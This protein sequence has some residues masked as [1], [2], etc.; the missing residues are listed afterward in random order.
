VCSEARDQEYKIQR[1]LLVDD[2]IAICN[3]MKAVFEDYGYDVSVVHNGKEGLEKFNA[4]PPDLVILDLHMPVMSGHDLLDNL[5]KNYP[6]I[7]KLV[8]SGVGVISEAMQTVNEGGWDFISKPINDLYVLI[9]K[10][11]L[12]EEKATLIRQNRLYKEHLEQLVEKRTADVQRLNLQVINT[13]KEIVAKLGD[14]IETRSQE[15]GNHVRRVAYLSRLLAI[16]YGLDSAEAEIVRMASPLHDVGKIGIPD[17]ILNKCGKLTEEEFEQIKTHTSIGYNMLKDSDQPIIIAGAIIAK[18]H[19]ERWDG[20][21][22]PDGLKGEQI[23]IY[24]RITCM[25]D[26]Y[27]ALRQKRHYKEA[28]S[29]EQTLDYIKENS[30]SFFEPKLVELFL[31]NI[32]EVETIIQTYR[33]PEMV[34]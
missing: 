18:E 22:Y 11:K 24:G 9:H 33:Q 2:E 30:G 16:A 6:E 14:V 29:E 17:A 7:P 25:A 32:A 12:L 13:Q 20:Q 5:S 23:H 4:H 26:I 28:W 8:I 34:I 21:G 19:H 10:I 27:D 31:Q 1:I 3:N 15:T